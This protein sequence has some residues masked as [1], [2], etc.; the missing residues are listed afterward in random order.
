MNEYQKCYINV[1]Q[2]SRVVVL[3]EGVRT[4]TT[5]GEFVEISMAKIRRFGHGS[6]SFTRN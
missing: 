5:P 2:A 6:R 1:N 4:V 3:R